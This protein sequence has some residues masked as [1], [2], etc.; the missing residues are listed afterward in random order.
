MTRQRLP[1]PGQHSSYEGAF[2][3]DDSNSFDSTPFVDIGSANDQAH[4]HTQRGLKMKQDPDIWSG[5]FV[6]PKGNATRAFQQL[7][8]LVYS[9]LDAL[10]EPR[11]TGF[12]ELPKLAYLG[13]MG[14]LPYS[15]N[16]GKSPCCLTGQSQDKLIPCG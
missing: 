2:P 14:N 1:F 6:D 13:H 11:E 4:R 15:M 9:W 8:H 3:D 16:I 10:T 5:P 7:L 12:M